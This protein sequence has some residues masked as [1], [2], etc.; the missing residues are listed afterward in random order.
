M[1]TRISPKTVVVYITKR[2]N[3][4]CPRCLWLLQDPDFFAKE[5]LNFKQ[6]KSIIAYYHKKYRPHFMVQ[7]EG[8]V[9]L[10]K[11]Y[12]RVLKYLHTLHQNITL[13]TNGIVLDKFFGPISKYI[14]SVLISIDGYDLE[15]YQ[16]IRGGNEQVFNR[17]V[18]NIKSLVSSGMCPVQT[19]TIIGTHNYTHITPMIRFLESIGVR[20]MNFGGYHAIGGEPLSIDYPGVKAYLK[21]VVS[22]TNYKGTITFRKLL[23]NT[24]SSTPCNMLFNTVLVGS[25]GHFTPCCHLAGKPEYGS[26]FDNPQAFNS[27]GIAELRTQFMKAKSGDDLPEICQNCPRRNSGISFVFSNGRWKGSGLRFL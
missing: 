14:G 3:S 7:A 10:H 17:V 24:A 9:L 8:E 27:G 11:D 22:C 26:F 21:R 12:T 13:I 25:Q 6:I 20:K 2:C 18:S 19:N 5:E 16:A 15:T 1:K 4:R 23:I